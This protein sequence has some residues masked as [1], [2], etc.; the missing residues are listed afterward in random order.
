LRD[1]LGYSPVFLRYNTGLHVSVNGRTLADILELLHDQ[2]P[3]PI[4]ELVLVGH[5]PHLGAD[6]EKSVNTASWAL[7][8]LPET[9]AIATF[10]NTRSDGVKDLRFGVCRRGLTLTRLNH[11]DLLN[12][13]R[14]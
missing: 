8:L 1:D 11:F 14:V 9:R 6:L 4:N 3:V 7:A 12:H 10:L 2:W 13:P 5:S